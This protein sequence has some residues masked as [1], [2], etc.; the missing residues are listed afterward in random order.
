M[1]G[2]FW[3]GTVLK[4]LVRAIYVKEREEKSQTT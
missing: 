3:V 1:N 4:P 2:T